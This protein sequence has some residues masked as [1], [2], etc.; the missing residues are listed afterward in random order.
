MRTTWE[1]RIRNVTSEQKEKLKVLASRHHKNSIQEY[2][3]WLIEQVTTKDYV[4]ETEIK[5]QDIVVQ[6]REQIQLLL[7]VVEENSTV[8]KKLLKELDG[9]E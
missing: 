6:Q 8:L 2:L 5:Y 3:L 4:V 7:S 9:D 1:I